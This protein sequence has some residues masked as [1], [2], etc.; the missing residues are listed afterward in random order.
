MR[1]KTLLLVGIA[2]S[3]I[4]GVW[5]IPFFLDYAIHS[6]FKQWDDSFHP[7]NYIVN[8]TY[9]ENNLQPF[10]DSFIIV[11]EYTLLINYTAFGNKMFYKTCSHKKG[12]VVTYAGYLGEFPTMF[13]VK[14]ELC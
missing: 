9:G 12:D 1:I 6:E 3:F 13:Y 10:A 7:G 4:I 11:N 2:A 5:S 14:R 8:G